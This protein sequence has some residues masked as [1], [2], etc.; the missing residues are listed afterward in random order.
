MTASKLEWW[1]QL[2]ISNQNIKEPIII[3]AKYVQKA[4]EMPWKNKYDSLYFQKLWIFSRH[5]FSN[6]VTTDSH[7]V[8]NMRLYQSNLKNEEK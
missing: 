6:A 8:H 7:L 4:I 3:F 2:S 1:W 5:I